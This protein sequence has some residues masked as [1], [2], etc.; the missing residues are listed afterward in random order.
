MRLTI[1]GY[2]REILFYEHPFRLASA[3]EHGVMPFTNYATQFK[4]TTDYI[5]YAHDQLELVAPLG[6]F[7][8]QWLKQSKLKGFFS[9]CSFFP[10][11]HLPLVARFKLLAIRDD[12]DYECFYDECNSSSSN[13]FMAGMLQ[14]PPSQLNQSATTLNR[15]KLIASAPL[16]MSTQQQHKH[17]HNRHHH[18]HRGQIFAAQWYI[19]QVASTDASYTDQVQTTGPHQTDI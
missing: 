14:T 5:F 18:H 16:N 15:A 17:Q 10:S 8:E 13:L 3:Y 19:K 9:R 1:D 2:E 7:D 6:P 12:D 4:A 11:D